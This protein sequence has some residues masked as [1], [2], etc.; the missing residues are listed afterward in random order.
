MTITDERAIELGRAVAAWD[1][2]WWSAGMRTM[3]DR[4]GRVW[5]LSWKDDERTAY[6]LTQESGRRL[7]HSAPCVG[8]MIPDLRD[9]PTQAAV[10][11][12]VG[13]TGSPMTDE[14]WIEIGRR[15]VACKH[16]RWLPGM[17]ALETNPEEYPGRVIDDRKSLVYEDGDG[18]IHE[19][20]ATRS[21]APDFRDPATLGCLLALVREAWEAP[22]MLWGGRVEV[23]QDHREVFCVA[24]PYHTQ[25]GF[26]R[27]AAISSGPTEAGALVAALEAAND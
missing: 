8:G 2:R 15:A 6:N 20:V 26:L 4:D 25:E 1:A 5:R 13:K 7:R 27:Y 12:R 11:E 3:P 23:H 21:D 22:D 14:Q 9:R 10:L 16:W 24:R 17:L 19:G 18:A